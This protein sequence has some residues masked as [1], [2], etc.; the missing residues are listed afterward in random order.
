MSRFFR[1]W[2]VRLAL[3]GCFG[4]FGLAGGWVLLQRDYTGSELV[5]YALKRLQG[6][7][8]LEMLAHPVLFAMQRHF[9]RPVSVTE[10]PTLGKGQQ[11]L[12]LNPSGKAQFNV[13]S[14]AEL[15]AAMRSAQA[16]QSIELQPGTYRLTQSLR[17][18][19]GGAPGL[20]IT[21][22]AA[23]PGSVT[24]E[25]ATIEGIVV[26]HPYWII[27]NLTLRGVCAEH[28][29]CEHA[30]HVVGGGQ[31]LTLQNNRFEDFNAHLKVNGLGGK[32]PDHGL[33]RFN[34]LL[35]QGV[36]RTHLPVVPIDIVGAS[37]WRVEDNLIR[38]FVMRD[39]NRISYGVFMKG[40]GREGRIERNL[41]VCTPQEI[42]QP[43]ARVGISMGGGGTGKQFC[44]DGKCT[45]EHV[46]GVIANNIV[47]HCN[48]FGIDINASDRITVAHN[49]LINTSGIDVRYAASGIR[50]GGNL[51][52]GRIRARHGSEIE[53][54]QNELR[55]AAELFTAP[56]TLQL[57]WLRLPERVPAAGVTHDFCQQPR[58]N[59]TLPGAFSSESGCS[60]P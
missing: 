47:A 43:G 54:A 10:L 7:P 17:T 56:D 18:A 29:L 5:R 50:V 51:L 12:T 40:A 1:R 14:V 35:N 3:L 9:E 25:V 8:K 34:T 33:I 21:L 20:P 60:R 30:I 38:N 6:H 15:A 13:A 49:T 57:G 53:A 59:G 31:H 19:Q 36:R 44:R 22:R 52:E 4:L 26:Q 37:H 27:E 46:D 58:Q 42:S 28:G 55:P 16:G 48:D 2:L 11:P 41:V 39:G 23:L 45:A 32:W 24:L